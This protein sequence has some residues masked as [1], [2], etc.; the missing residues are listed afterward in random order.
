MTTS[1][2]EQALKDYDYLLVAHADK[3]F[4]DE[5]SPLFGSERVQDGELFKVVKETG[6]LNLR[7][8]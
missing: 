7:K 2:F 3:K 1:E 4:A 6:H 5:F 8:I